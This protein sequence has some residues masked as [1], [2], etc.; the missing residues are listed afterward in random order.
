MAA[1]VVISTKSN[2]SDY[3]GVQINIVDTGNL[4]PTTAFYDDATKVLNIGIDL[5]AANWSDVDTALSTSATTKDIFTIA[6]DTAGAATTA[7]NITMAKSYIDITAV[8]KG[9]D[10]NNVK[11][12]IA[13][14]NYGAGGAATVSYNEAGKELT[15][16]LNDHATSYTSQF[17]DGTTLSSLVTAI[18]GTGYFT[19]AASGVTN[20]DR[21]FGNVSAD[22]RAMANTSATGYL[23]SAFSSHTRAE[24][25]LTLAAGA[26]TA[27]WTGRNITYTYATGTGSMEI[28]ANTPGSQYDGTTVVLAATGGVAAGACCYREDPHDY[29]GRRQHD[30]T[31]QKRHRQRHRCHRCLSVPPP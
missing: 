31:D 24:A 8:D 3:D 4:T 28:K 29:L 20:D 2:S 11:V 26:N 7:A 15:I 10:F 17:D 9:I 1:G 25:T 27:V 6:V 22:Q 30:G 23:N 19:A 21:V 14:Q 18:T 16:T 5:G 12:S 13:H